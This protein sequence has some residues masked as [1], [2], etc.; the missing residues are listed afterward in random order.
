MRRCLIQPYWI[1][2]HIQDPPRNHTG[3]YRRYSE[4]VSR[5]NKDGS[6]VASERIDKN[7]IE[8]ATSQCKFSAYCK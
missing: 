8:R 7:S 2:V 1:D 5:Q 4:N 6:P 3:P